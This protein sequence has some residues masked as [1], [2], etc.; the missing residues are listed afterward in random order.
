MA[1]TIQ[2]DQIVIPPVHSDMLPGGIGL[3]E[4]TTF[5]RV[6]SQELYK[7]LADMKDRGLRGL[8]LDLRNNSG[9]LLSEAR[10]VSELFLPAGKVVVSTESRVGRERSYPTQADAFVPEDIPVVVLINRFSA[11][12]SEIVAGA[13]CKT[14]GARCSSASAAYGKGSV[15][16]LIRVPGER[17]DEF[18][19][20]NRNRRFDNWESITKDWNQNGEFDFAPRVK[21]T[22]ERYLLP[23]GRSIHRELDEEGNLVSPGG[24][25]P[26][27][28]V[29]PKRWPQWKLEEILRIQGDRTVQTWARERFADNRQLFEQLA[30][31]DMDD[32]SR[33]PEFAELYASLD[34]TLTEADVRFLARREARRLVQDA[35][36]EA[37]PLGGDYQ[38]DLQLQQAIRSLLAEIGDSVDDVPA[39][40]ATF[41]EAPEGSGRKGP[42]VAKTSGLDRDRLERAQALI[43][44]ASDGNGR[45]SDEGLQTLSEIIEDALQNKN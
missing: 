35:R 22:V 8:I 6:A 25:E 13:L 7:R 39:Y 34:T 3:V 20:E 41:D 24:V 17:D 30:A 45:I 2:R 32:S 10:N 16:N 42:R 26:D 37:F 5:S 1:V 21:L 19:D 44:E 29:A 23:T 15:Q 12:A 11:S 4:L 27:E 38:E 31:G 28:E 40:A 43:A 9:G 36:G 14:T 18:A 33:Y